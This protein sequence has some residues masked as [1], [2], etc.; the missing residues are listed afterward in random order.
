M[1][2]VQ[3]HNSFNTVLTYLSDTLF[4]SEF[5]FMLIGQYVLL[6]R[7]LMLVTLIEFQKF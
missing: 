5:L 6:Q 3:K 4:M 2:K 1:D 7:Y